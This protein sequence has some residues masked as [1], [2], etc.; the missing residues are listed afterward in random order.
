MTDKIYADFIKTGQ[1]VHF[2]TKMDVILTEPSG[3]I[4]FHSTDHSLPVVLGEPENDYVYINETIGQLPTNNYFHHMN[5][6]G[7]EY[8]AVGIHTENAFKGSL[9]IGPFISSLSINTL[10]QDIIVKNA[11]PIG[12][13]K[14]LEQFYQ[15]LPILNEIDTHYYGELLIN[16]CSGTYT[17]AE[18]AAG[19]SKHPVINY[20]QIELTIE[21]DKQIIENRYHHQN[22]MMDAIRKGDQE[23]VNDSLH[24]MLDLFVGF[25]DRVPGS[26]MRSSKNMALISNTSFR[27]A[28]EKSGVHPVY[29]HIISERYAVLIEKT[30][31][32]P[33]LKKLIISMANEYCELVRSFATGHYSQNVKKAMD[34]IML[35]LGQPIRL[36][37]ISKQIHV[38]PSHLSRK[39]KEESG[40]TI[41]E[42]IT[43]KRIEEAELYLQKG[44]TSIT[45][46]A[47]ILGFN[48]LNYFSKVFKKYTGYTPSQ[49]AKN[50][51]INT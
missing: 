47:F 28:A 46:I 49:Y 31:T 29:L 40:I 5:T 8:I 24:T 12:E 41:T 27:I 22:E 2:T 23:A 33:N 43:Q 35:N 32:L 44:N 38:N 48:D 45:D 10:I 7:L 17:P 20:D 30:A 26:P 18:E 15:S 6:Y 1:I 16:M 9:I 42:F 50:N 34:Y 25:S 3:N 21:E 13:R 39:F 4:I 11:L 37:Q 14:Q 36:S 51:D 19:G